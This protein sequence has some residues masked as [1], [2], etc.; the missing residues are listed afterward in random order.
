M[1]I[2]YSWLCEYLPLSVNGQAIPGVEEMSEILTSL[3]MEVEKSETYESIRGG[4]QGLIVGEVLECE[5]HP[6]A[7][8]LS[9]T[10]VNLGE[11]V[12]Q[13]VCGA[14]NVQKGQK[15]I[16]AP[17]GSTIYPLTGEPLTMKKIRIR[18]VESDGMICAEDEIGIGTSHMGIMILDTAAA[19]G[20][21]ASEVL[22]S[23]TD[24]VFEIGLT[25]N[26]MDAMSHI[27][28]ARDVAAYLGHHRNNK[29]DLRLPYK[30]LPVIKPSPI[31]VKIEDNHA[32]MRYSGILIRDIKMSESPGWLKNRLVAIGVKPLNVI[33]DITNYVLHETGQPLHAFDADKI[34]GNKIVVRKAKEKEKFI[35]LDQKER[36]LSVTDLV[37]CD[38]SDPMCLAGIFGGAESG[39]SSDTT[40]VF[41]E[42]AWF[43]PE[44]TRVSSLK[45]GL[46][47][48]AA[49]RFEKGVDISNVINAL[50]RA[51]ALVTEHAGG[52]IEGF[53]DIY[54]SP[55]EK[56][57]V[58]FT[59]SYLQKISGKKYTHQTITG[60]LSSLGFNFLQEKEGNYVVQVPYSKP[61]ITLPADIAEEILRV[62]GLNNIEL[63][64]T[65]TI[66]PQAARN[67]RSRLNREKISQALS[68]S[69]Y[70]EIFTNSISFSGLFNES[71]IR[72]LNSLSNELDCLRPEMLHSG[73]EVIAYNHHRK[74][75][76]TRFY[77]FGKTYHNTENGHRETPRLAIFLS[78]EVLPADWKNKTREADF[79]I[80]KGITERIL[81]MLGHTFSGKPVQKEGYAYCLELKSGRKCGFIG[82]VSAQLLSKYDIRQPVFVADLDWEYISSNTEEVNYQEISKFPP[83]ERDLAIVI[84][85]ETE[86]SEVEK[87]TRAARI[88]HLASVKLFDVFESEKLGTGK[89]SLAL[90]YTFSSANSTLTD[91]EIDKQMGKLIKSY[92]SQLNAEIRK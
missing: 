11:K 23:Y 92:E 7:D 78:S 74:N 63:P 29:A 37:V 22:H 34:K 79:F 12:S 43:H 49:T 31:T 70:F 75:N 42:S 26:R 90:N 71:P 40:S 55:P 41:L 57:Q 54:P 21:P 4:L 2:S 32:C 38:A 91:K 33:V 80:L 6:D 5:K 10:K 87:V 15:V 88:E 8:K 46:R 81:T 59:G 16:V 53:T 84:S 60:I 73:L 76:S 18:G 65:I 48:D 27:G 56:K 20:T 19:P 51:A 85:K 52:T 30:P 36:E 89:K 1:T 62:D 83:S 14:P 13:I 9:I 61:D 82:S 77:E 58:P 3:G 24:H 28:V 69:G 86:F 25:P 50:E 47:T 64:G 39:I 66:S 44:V 45:H 68:G 67:N 17:V 72:M 35:T